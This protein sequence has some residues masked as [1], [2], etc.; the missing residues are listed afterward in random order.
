M[1]LSSPRICVASV[2]GPPSAR[3]G[4]LG[5][6]VINVCAF[7]LLLVFSQSTGSSEILHIL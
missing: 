5:T 4:D 3:T 1:T 2:L 6:G 7:I